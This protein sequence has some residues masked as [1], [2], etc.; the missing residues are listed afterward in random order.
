MSWQGTAWAEKQKTGSPARKVLLLVLANYA[1]E[2]GR[3]W[4]SQATLS[5]GTEQSI[6]TVQRQ[7]R[8]LAADGHI[9][10]EKRQRRGG[11]WPAH[12]YQLNMPNR[13]IAE[14]QNAARSPAKARSQSVTVTVDNSGDLRLGRAATSTATGPQALRYEYLDNI[15]REYLAKS[16]MPQCV[17]APKAIRRS[18]AV[19][20]DWKQSRDNFRA[21]RSTLKGSLDDGTTDHP[22]AVRRTRAE[23]QSIQ[24]RVVEK[25]GNGNQADGWIRFG[26]LTSYQR[27]SLENL[28]E[29]GRLDQVE[30]AA[31]LS[32]VSAVS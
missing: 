9:S 13:R 31:A 16:P 12:A 3:C 1:D 4:P 8:K 15:Q 26:G 10:T 27:Q 7:L 32:A 5:E 19:A 30:I 25:L 18:G 22:E 6:D 17:E 24:R 14:P 20:G 28:E 29:Q 21:A 2:Y 23:I 11:H